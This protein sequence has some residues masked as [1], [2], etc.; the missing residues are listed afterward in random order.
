MTRGF[1]Q[2]P[3]SLFDISLVE[4]L[5]SSAPVTILLPLLD[6]LPSTGIFPA[7]S[8]ATYRLQS[9]EIR[10][11]FSRHHH[12]HHYYSSERHPSSLPPYLSKRP[13]RSHPRSARKPD[14]ESYRFRFRQMSWE[15]WLGTPCPSNGRQ[16][17]PTERLRTS[18]PVVCSYLL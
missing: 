1:L 13:H 6:T 5:L 10:A 15:S 16:H 17:I 3:S 4:I 14:V 8:P 11:R 12:H 9:I 7:N 18:Y 2:Q